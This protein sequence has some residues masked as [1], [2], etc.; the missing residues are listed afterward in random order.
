MYGDGGDFAEVAANARKY[1]MCDDQMYAIFFVYYTKKKKKKRRTVVVV[2]RTEHGNNDAHTTTSSLG[3][4]SVRT[5]LPN[6]RRRREPP[7]RV[8][9]IFFFV[10]KGNGSAI[11]IIPVT[12]NANESDGST[13]FIFRAGR[14]GGAKQ[15]LPSRSVFRTDN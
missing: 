7:T 8:L 4:R 9:T 3:F 1:T 15:Q 11:E 6:G 5:P 10:S 13:T 12:V 14:H 2:I